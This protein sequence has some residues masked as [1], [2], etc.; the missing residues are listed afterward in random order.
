MRRFITEALPEPGVF[1]VW[2]TF[3]DGMTHLLDLQ[4]IIGLE[5]Y[6]VLRLRKAFER[7]T[8]SRDGQRLEWPGGIGLSADDLLTAPGDRL[9]LIRIARLPSRQRFRPLLPFLKHLDMGIYLRPDPVQAST[10]LTLLRMKP[11]ELD[12]AL[13]QLRAPDELVLG[14]LCDLGVLLLEY[15]CGDDLSRLLRRPW[16]YST[17]QCPGRPMLHTMLGCLMYGRPDL[18]ERPCV[19]LATGMTIP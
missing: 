13:K 11:T 8:V 16:R 15:F 12:T 3:D 4:G 1:Q 5:E 17:E 19:L 2:V 6:R 9:H 7:V 10:V 18:I 14:R